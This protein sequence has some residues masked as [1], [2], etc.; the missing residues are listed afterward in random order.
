MKFK[1]E[2]DKFYLSY[3]NLPEKMHKDQMPTN[4]QMN[5]QSINHVLISP[6]TNL[7]SSSHDM[8]RGCI[9]PRSMGPDP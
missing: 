4:R 8:L 9:W 5:K 3:L 2:E 1:Q 7:V 6:C